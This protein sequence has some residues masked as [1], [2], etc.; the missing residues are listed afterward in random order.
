MVECL[1]SMLRSPG[2]DPQQGIKK[3]HC[4]TYWETEAGGLEIQDHPQPHNEFESSLC[5]M[6]P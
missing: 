1:T 5:Y 6:R 4:G 2:F 3:E